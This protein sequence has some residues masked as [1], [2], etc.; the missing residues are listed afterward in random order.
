[1]TDDMVSKTVKMANDMKR[2]RSDLSAQDMKKIANNV[3]NG[4]EK[5]NEKEL[6]TLA[7]TK[8]K[9]VLGTEFISTP[10]IESVADNMNEINKL[11]PENNKDIGPISGTI[12][13]IEKKLYAK[14]GYQ[15]LKTRLSMFMANARRAFGGTA[16][17]AN[18]M[19]ALEDFIGGKTTMNVSNLSAM[20]N[21]V[22]KVNRNEYNN[23]QR[24]YGIPN[25]RIDKEAR[26]SEPS[27]QSSDAEIIDFL[28]Q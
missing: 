24:Q 22:F 6:R 11:I 5:S 23:Q 25:P 27:K 13:D 9:S 26:T 4:N 2:F 20:L 8:V 7:D 14:T 12:A 21:T 15:D 28:N 3:K 16:V 1:M 17:T 18:E 10:A 19:A